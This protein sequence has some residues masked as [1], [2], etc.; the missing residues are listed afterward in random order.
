MSGD[1]PNSEVAAARGNRRRWL[2]RPLPPSRRLTQQLTQIQTETS[3]LRLRRATSPAIWARPLWAGPRAKWPVRRA[4]TAY[5][6]PPAPSTCH[7]GWGDRFLLIQGN[8]PALSCHGD[9]HRSGNLKTLDYGETAFSGAIRCPVEPTGITCTDATTR[10]SFASQANR[11]NCTEF[12][13][14][15]SRQGANRSSTR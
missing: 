5:V 7:L 4:N 2:S 12:S 3:W 6:A 13:G 11:M 14:H 8:A 10:L 15:V 9:T 1:Q